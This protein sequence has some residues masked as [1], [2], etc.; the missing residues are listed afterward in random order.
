[1]VYHRSRMGVSPKTVDFFIS[2]TGKD[3]GWAKWAVGVLQAAGYSTVTQVHDFRPGES[4]IRNM[5]RAL[6][7]SKRTL[8]L[9]SPEYL[10]SKYC[11]QEWE[12][13]F[14]DEVLVP[15]IVRPCKLDG[16]LGPLAYVDLSAFSAD[17]T[18]AAKRELLWAV[19]AAPAPGASPFP[20]QAQRLPGV[21]PQQNNLSHLRNPH[22]GGRDGIL[23]R[24][25]SEL[26]GGSPAAS[27]QA[28][29][30][31]GGTGKTQLALE[32]CYRYS[33]DYDAI[34]WLHAED[35]AVLATEY[36][37]LATALGFEDLPQPEAIGAVRAA[38]SKKPRALLV[39][40]NATSPESVEPYLPLGALRRVI[41]TSRQQHWPYAS[42]QE[43]RAMAPK[44]AQAFLL[45]RTGQADARAAALVAELL[46]GLP[47]ALEQ[48]AAYVGTRRKSLSSY[49]QLLQARGLEVLEKE[50][51]YGYEKTVGT[52]WDLAM[53]EVASECPAAAALLRYCAFLA[54]DDIRLSDL[55]ASS[56]HLPEPLHSAASDELALDDAKAALLRYSLISVGGAGDSADSD[57]LGDSIAVHR[58]VQQVTRERMG[59]D[60]QRSWRGVALRVIDGVFPDQSDDVRYWPDCVRL[61]PH[62]GVVTESAVAE[63][64]DSGATAGL[65]DRSA[66]Y[67]QYSG[68]YGDAEPLFRRALA[69]A[70]ASRGADHPDVAIHL[71]NLAELL[72]VTN[73]L[74]EAEPLYRRTLSI[75]ETALGSD[76]PDVAIRLNN[77]A[78]LLKATNRLEEAEEL[79]RRALSISETSLGS[80]HPDVAI[81]LNNL[82]LLLK[83]T[84]RLEEAEQLVR[85]A[86]TIGETSLGPEHP[87]VAIRLNNLA[88]LLQAGNRLEEA[89]ALY[90]RA[91]SIREASLGTKHP[92]VAQTLNNLA[93]LLKSTSRL[94]EAEPLLRRAFA[95][96]EARLGAEHPNTVLVRGNL[97]RLLGG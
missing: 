67:L 29:T 56:E 37:A 42:T 13:A 88:V 76:H 41:I 54:P 94:E 4:F 78:L 85:R 46:G 36:A 68:A 9:F 11:R 40:D 63:E 6:Q 87:D 69:I 5:H 17:D 16:V 49:A 84:N 92:D 10:S 57:G 91:L 82:A 61:L 79:Y 34:F 73:R 66:T 62:V 28:A 71:N 55:A 51:A 60:E 38:L 97:E 72:R 19:G 7:C 3:V 93:M 2:Y 21:L 1:M 95:I 15:I 48:A 43:I 58:L 26:C 65:L 52:T 45:A 44:E 20:G 22:F 64:A 80:E 75:S 23:A 24:L 35:P 86:L 14:K 30:G 53:D 70:E 89:E 47:L 74:A 83:A 18:E 31:L 39:F 77:L 59:P 32:Y 25:H 8:G 50:R 90:R 33:A 96:F 12:A 27:T 81:Q